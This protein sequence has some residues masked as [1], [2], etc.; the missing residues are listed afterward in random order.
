MVTRHEDVRRV[1]T[2][3]GFSAD[4]FHPDFPNFASTDQPTGR[5]DDDDRS[6]LMSVV[7]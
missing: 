1:L 2:D 4:R 7:N 3:P 6:L 5:T